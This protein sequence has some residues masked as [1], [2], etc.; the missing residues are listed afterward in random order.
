MLIDCVCK[1]KKERNKQRKEGEERRDVG[2][3]EENAKPLLKK[4]E[5]N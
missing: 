5:K 3:E 2:L 4:S 1:K